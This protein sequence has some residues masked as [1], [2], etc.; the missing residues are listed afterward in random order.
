MFGYLTPHNA[1]ISRA[2]PCFDINFGDLSSC[3]VLNVFLWLLCIIKWAK[4]GSYLHST[5]IWGRFWS[6]FGYLTPIGCPCIWL[7]PFLHLEMLVFTSMTVLKWGNEIQFNISINFIE[8]KTLDPQNVGQRTPRMQVVFLS[9]T[10]TC[11]R[12]QAKTTIIYQKNS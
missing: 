12:K 5:C 1:H 11:K 6:K 2:T 3:V 4:W 7:T 10:I 9:T 8:E